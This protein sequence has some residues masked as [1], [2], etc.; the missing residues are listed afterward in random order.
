MDGKLTVNGE[1][2]TGRR[3]LVSGDLIEVSGLTLEFT[4]SITDI[5]NGMHVA[6]SNGVRY[7]IRC[8]DPRRFTG[9]F[10]LFAVPRTRRRSRRRCRR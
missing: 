5:G 6:L 2:V 3:D 9:N 1:K 4:L 10:R 8:P 7:H